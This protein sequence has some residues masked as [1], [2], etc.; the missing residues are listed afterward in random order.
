MLNKH[1]LDV[2]IHLPNPNILTLLTVSNVKEANIPGE[3]DTIYLH[4][5][6]G[7]CSAS[8]QQIT[9]TLGQEENDFLHIELP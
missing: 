5:I 2:I 7:K 8:T 6:S 9:F 1:A 4:N 3:K